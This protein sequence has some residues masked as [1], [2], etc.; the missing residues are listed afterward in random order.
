MWYPYWYRMPYMGYGMPYPPPFYTPYP[1]TP[2]DELRMLEEY[3]RELERELEYLKE[4]L[5]GVKARIE[6]LRKAA[7]KK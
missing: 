3:K 5:E 2:E 6:E 1:P 4:E 7:G